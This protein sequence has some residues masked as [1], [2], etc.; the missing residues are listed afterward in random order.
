VIASSDSLMADAIG[1][2]ALVT[3]LAGP[4]GPESCRLALQPLEIVYGTPDFGSGYAGDELRAA[5]WTQIIKALS[6][7]PLESLEKAVSAYIATSK[8]HFFPNPGTLRDLCETDTTLIRTV[9]YRIKKAVEAAPVPPRE[10]SPEEVA[11]VARL[12]AELK[13]KL[14]APR[15]MPDAP[16]LRPVGGY[17]S[18]LQQEIIAKGLKAAAQ[19]PDAI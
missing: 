13:G 6:D 19:A 7:L 14:G 16:V 15:S 3:R 17:Q 2:H 18:P 10:K 4:C 12:L 1:C 8:K 11:E 9:A 5:W